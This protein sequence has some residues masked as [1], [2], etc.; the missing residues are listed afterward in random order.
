MPIS[1]VA[2]LC[3]LMKVLSCLFLSAQLKVP[4]NRQRYEKTDS[5]SRG[6]RRA[7]NEKRSFIGKL[8]DLKS[9]RPVKVNKQLEQHH[10]HQL[11]HLASCSFTFFVPSIHSISTIRQS[12]PTNNAIKTPPAPPN[13]Y[14]LP[15]IPR[16]FT[17]PQPINH[18]PIRS[19]LPS[20]GFTRPR[21]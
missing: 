4:G 16:P 6:E 9:P 15:L 19:L 7:Q 5:I 17:R 20:A 13:L 11:D 3:T 14:K 21:R 18:L 1:E 12:H 8:F 2:T 10:D